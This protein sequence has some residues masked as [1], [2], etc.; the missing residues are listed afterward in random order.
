MIDFISDN[1]V[2][3]VFLKSHE[4]AFEVLNRPMP[5]KQTVRIIIFHAGGGV[6]AMG[7]R[8]ANRPDGDNGFAVYRSTD[9][10]ELADRADEICPN[11]GFKGSVA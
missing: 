11:G 4:P 9:M 2:A 6:F 1:F 8:W 3:E 10:D 5:K 7:V